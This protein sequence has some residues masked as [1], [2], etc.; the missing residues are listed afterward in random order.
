M[1]T[2]TKR[3]CMIF[4]AL[5]L[6]VS[7]VVCD[8][9]QAQA[10][11]W[12][13]TLW[14]LSEVMGTL[15][16]ML[17]ITWTAAEA[18]ENKDIIEKDAKSI[19]ESMKSAVD[20]ELDCID[21]TFDIWLDGVVQDAQETGRI[22]MDAGSDGW[23]KL[24]EWAADMFTGTD[25]S[26]VGS[27]PHEAYPT[28]TPGSIADTLSIQ[29]P[30]L[31]TAQMEQIK[32]KYDDT[33]YNALTIYK[34][35]DLGTTYVKPWA[36]STNIPCTVYYYYV[37]VYDVPSNATVK[38]AYTD[39]SSTGGGLYYSIYNNDGAFQ[40][41]I[42]AVNKN[43]FVYKVVLNS[44]NVPIY[45]YAPS[46]GVSEAIRWNQGTWLFDGVVTDRNG[47]GQR[48]ACVNDPG[49]ILYSTIA[50][51]GVRG[52]LAPDVIFPKILGG[53]SVPD[54]ILNL[55]NSGTYPDAYDVVVPGQTAG[56]DEA[57]NKVINGDIDVPVSDIP[58]G[59]VAEGDAV[60]DLPI[61]GVTPV[62]KVGDVVIDTD[63]PI[64]D[65]I[66]DTINP[67][68]PTDD[69]NNKLKY[70]GWTTIFP[71]CIPFDLVRCFEVLKTKPVAPEW[72]Y[73][74]KVDSLNFEYTFHLNFD[75]VRPLVTI[76]RTGVLLTFIV[77]LILVTRNIIKG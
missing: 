8:Y 1:K 22:V 20:S 5:Y 14:S 35:K 51:D 24:K 23:H 33:D 55:I 62:D 56:E 7:T 37:T 40:K 16:G 49:R 26:K 74:L 11:E 25:G 63:I 73:T 69:K 45:E 2:I 47:I 54:S 29:L 13:Y 3:I 53:L 64:D 44:N 15:L 39:E 30:Y 41:S 58:V 60:I 66:D 42:N 17:G 21:E 31:T 4:M 10:A 12:A 38:G 76:F 68:P 32:A 46:Y 71:F 36:G 59:G 70:D 18:Y 19:L 57:G 27:K 65:V 50:V 61:P 77:G 48:L 67:D 6:S 72:E 43:G 9:Q 34:Y 28:L 52:D 75:K